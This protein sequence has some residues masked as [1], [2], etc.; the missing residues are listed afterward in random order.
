[1][2]THP[3]LNI[4][5]TPPTP[6]LLSPLPAITPSIDYETADG[7]GGKGG[8]G[9]GSGGV[10]YNTGGGGGMPS[11]ELICQE[12]GCGIALAPGCKFCP[13]CGHLAPYRCTGCH[14]QV[15][16]GALQRAVRESR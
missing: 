8:G 16:G 11:T 9:T 7:V 14:S 3:L 1:M 13:V 10:L 2:K 15:R 6:P 12:Q 4:L 5:L